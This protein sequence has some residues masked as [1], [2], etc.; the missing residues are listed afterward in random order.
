MANA[1]DIKNYFSVEGHPVTNKEFIEFRKG[2]PD[3]YNEVKDLL[4]G[5]IAE[6]ILEDFVNGKYAD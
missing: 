6:Q 3:G 2:D 4:D 1:T 5:E